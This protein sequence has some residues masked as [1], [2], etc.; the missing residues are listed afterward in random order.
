RTPTVVDLPAPFGPKR[1]KISPGKMSREI[2]SSATISGLGC[3]PYL[4]A[5]AHQTRS[6]PRRRPREELS[7]RPCASRA[8]ECQL[9]CPS[10]V[11]GLLKTRVC[12]K[13]LRRYHHW[14]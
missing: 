13:V 10:S 7:C 2:P 5:L 6:L 14:N 9:P 11:S 3:C 4:L 8:C 1:Q 12:A